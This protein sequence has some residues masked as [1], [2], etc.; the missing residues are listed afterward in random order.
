VFRGL[1][2]R[3][4]P[5]VSSKYDVCYRLLPLTYCMED[6]VAFIA[7]VITFKSQLNKT[8]LTNLLYKRFKVEGVMDVL[9]NFYFIDYSRR[10]T[11]VKISGR[12]TSL[13]F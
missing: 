6:K 13:G 2:L 7:N 3:L 12:V 5:L 11:Q 10:G 1:E 4:N 8:T 9:S